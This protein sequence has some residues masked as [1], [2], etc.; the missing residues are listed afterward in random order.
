MR[1]TDRFDA[2]MLNTYA[3]MLSD[4][5]MFDDW[6][7]V[8]IVPRNVEEYYMVPRDG[9]PTCSN[10]ANDCESKRVCVING[11]A[12]TKAYP[13][14]NLPVGTLQK[15]TRCVLCIR[16]DVEVSLARN[17]FDGVEYSWDNTYR[18]AAGHELDHLV[19]DC[20]DLVTGNMHFFFFEH[21]L[22]R[23]D[24]SISGAISHEKN[25]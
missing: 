4:N 1:S 23:Y 18:N 24:V 11:I 10:S 20:H 17:S 16:R 19:S 2:L 15:E 7:K 12:H 22:E 14:F 6:A 9:V 8:S 5:Q 3:T 13:S 25:R 21:D